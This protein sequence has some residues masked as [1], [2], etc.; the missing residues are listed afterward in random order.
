[1]LSLSLPV[2]TTHSDVS[3][4]PTRENATYS[5][6]WVCSIADIAWDEVYV[7]VHP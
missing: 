5:T 4:G 2:L 6:A 7:D 1:V 3:V